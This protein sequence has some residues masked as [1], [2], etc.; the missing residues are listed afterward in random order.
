MVSRDIEWFAKEHSCTISSIIFKKSPRY[1]YFTICLCLTFWYNSI[2][3]LRQKLNSFGFPHFFS[4]FKT[5]IPILNIHTA[6]FNWVMRSRFWTRIHTFYYFIQFSTFSGRLLHE[7][8]TINWIYNIIIF[9][10]ITPFSSNEV[11]YFMWVRSTYF[12]WVHR[13]PDRN[14]VWESHSHILN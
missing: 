10:C 13:G 5:D 2:N 1:Y 6:I 8:F 12:P 14:F 11:L 3:A 9:F 4:N 7:N